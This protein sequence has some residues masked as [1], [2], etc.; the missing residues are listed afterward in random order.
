M[1]IKSLYPQHL[2]N[3]HLI[4]SISQREKGVQPVHKDK[5]KRHPV[6]G[7]LYNPFSG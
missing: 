3:T 4:P 1:K 6:T 5:L 7:I 2:H